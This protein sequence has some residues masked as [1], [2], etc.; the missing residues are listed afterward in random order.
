MYSCLYFGKLV[1]IRRGPVAHRFRYGISMAYLDL[2]EADELVRR[3]RILSS[4]WLPG[5][6]VADDHRIG[7]TP[8]RS[9]AEL[10]RRVRAYAEQVSGRP[11]PGPVRMLTQLRHFG[12]F[13]S[14]LN[15]FYLFDGAGSEVAAIVAEVSNTPWN[16]R[17]WYVLHAGNRTAGVRSMRFVH[18]KDFHVSPF[19]GMNCNYEWQL[20]CPEERLHVHIRARNDGGTPFDARMRLT[21]R[22]WSER[23]LATYCCRRPLA[24]LQILSAI[25][26]Q[27]LLLWL[28][29]CPLYP[30]A[31]GIP[32]A[33][34]N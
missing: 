12:R 8:V 29:R 26:W 3:S 4:R 13:F 32:N 18:R 2:D 10:A 6:F 31:S 1:H 28:K 9:A 30:H 11:A 7:P 25:Y 14:P 24:G 21:R 22:P 33:D 27:A 34:P 5:S 19:M 15:L 20:N 17:R 23:N 16:E